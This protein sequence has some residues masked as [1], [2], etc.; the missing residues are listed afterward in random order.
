M[1]EGYDPHQITYKE[2]DV[3]STNQKINHDKIKNLKNK[4][5]NTTMVICIFLILALFYL[6]WHFTKN[7]NRHNLFV[8]LGVFLLL[9]YVFK[10]ELFVLGIVAILYPYSFVYDMLTSE[11]NNFEYKNNLY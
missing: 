10:K 8:G 6:I 7:I 2:L 4:I 11:K 5:M 1:I 3:Y 9:C